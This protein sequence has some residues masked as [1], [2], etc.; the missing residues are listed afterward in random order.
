MLI[1]VQYPS[2]LFIVAVLSLS[3]GPM[4]MDYQPTWK[5]YVATCLLES[6]VRSS[7]LKARVT[8]CKLPWATYP[9]YQV[10]VRFIG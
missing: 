7:V 6:I 3:W 5:A 4:L 2:Y 9:V 1:L 10:I 8:T